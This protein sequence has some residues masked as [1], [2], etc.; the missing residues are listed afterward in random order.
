[1]KRR[2]DLRTGIAALGILSLIAVGSVSATPTEAAWTEPE[3]GKT[4]AITAATL[5]A[6]TSATCNANNIIL[7]GL[8]DFTVRWSSPQIDAQRVQITINGVTGTDTQEIK[9]TGSSNG[10]YQYQAKY[11]TAKLLSL[12]NLTT[13]LGDVYTIQIS[14]GYPGSAWWSKPTSFNLTVALLG[15]SA[16]CRPT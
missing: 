9:R 13:L 11:S 14:S 16:T 10:V 6:P 3:Y 2:K 1:M 5:V 8:Q 7:L 15:L 12:V 4:N